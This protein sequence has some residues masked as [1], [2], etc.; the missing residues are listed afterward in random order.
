LFDKVTNTGKALDVCKPTK[1]DH[2]FYLTSFK[3]FR[4]RFHHIKRC[5]IIF[6]IEPSL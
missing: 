4:F 1:P 5:C 3:Q 6:T 2:I